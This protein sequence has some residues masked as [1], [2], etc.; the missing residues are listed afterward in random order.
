MRDEMRGRQ[1]HWKYR[2][3]HSTCT[4]QA[5]RR[6][7]RREHWK[8]QRSKDGLQATGYHFP[9]Q[10]SS[11]VI[12]WLST[13]LR[14]KDCAMAETCN[15]AYKMFL[16]QNANIFMLSQ[17]LNAWA[18]CDSSVT[19]RSATNAYVEC[20]WEWNNSERD[21]GSVKYASYS[22]RF[23]VVLPNFCNDKTGHLVN[24]S[25]LGPNGLGAPH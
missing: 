2:S 9:L 1:A 16:A 7:R 22:S 4:R 13:E 21:A 14:V 15:T 8:E 25:K 5:G 6:G 24:N 18:L 10:F 11:R 20:Y 23:L 17:C 3:I 12:Q 19:I